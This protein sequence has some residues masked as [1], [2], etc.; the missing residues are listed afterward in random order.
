MLKCLLEEHTVGTAFLLTELGRGVTPCPN[1]DGYILTIDEV[2]CEKRTGLACP[3]FRSLCN[4]PVGAAE[5]YQLDTRAHGYGA[6]PGEIQR[7]AD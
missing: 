3:R 5:Q 4:G 2:T 1:N 6:P 7:G